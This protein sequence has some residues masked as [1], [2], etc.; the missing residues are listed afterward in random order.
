MVRPSLDFD[1]RKVATLRQSTS[2]SAISDGF[3]Q[4]DSNWDSRSPVS[5]VLA[6]APN[7]SAA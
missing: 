3:R 1:S 7:R 6:A 4:F 2:S 5:S